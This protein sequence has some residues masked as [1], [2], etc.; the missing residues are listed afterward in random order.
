MWDLLVFALIGLLVGAAAR[1]LYPGRQPVSILTTLIIGMLG[2]L[3]GWVIS[4]SLWPMEDDQYHSGN[5]LVAML[6]A[7]IAIVF[8]ACVTYARSV[9]GPR[10]TSG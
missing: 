6:G 1:L 9:S 4:W 2:A 5:V 8:G 3:G 10:H 7:I